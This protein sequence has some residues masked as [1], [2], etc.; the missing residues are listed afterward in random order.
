MSVPNPRRRSC[1]RYSDE[2]IWREFMAG[3]LAR[4]PPKLA[5]VQADEAY[6]EY[7][8]RFPVRE[9]ELDDEAAALEPDTESEASTIQTKKGVQ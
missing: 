8:E 2:R 9:P 7:R 3:C 4:H 6:T 5:A 1:R